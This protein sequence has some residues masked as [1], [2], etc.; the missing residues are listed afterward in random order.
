MRFLLDNCM[1]KP[2]SD[3]LSVFDQRNSISAIRDHFDPAIKDA[4]WIPRVAAW[5]EPPFVLSGD[6][7]ILR[8][9][10][11]RQVLKQ[12]GLTFFLMSNS[13]ASERWESYA[14]RLIKVWPRIV[15][16]AKLVT[17][18][19]VFEVALTGDKVMRKPNL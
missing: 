11:E 17:R 18:P 12:S 7:R 13:W 2:A 3:M 10:V 9:A 15:E 1:P 6:G 5:D 14:W 8:N 16:E 4:E 19:T